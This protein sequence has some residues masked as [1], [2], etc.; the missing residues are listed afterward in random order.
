MT[1][2]PEQSHLL[3]ADSSLRSM[4]KTHQKI[5]QP[6]GNILCLLSC[7][8][9]VPSVEPWLVGSSLRQPWQESQLGCWLEK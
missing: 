9:L 6:F 3:D 2:S 7:Q 1:K 8:L 4:L 5:S